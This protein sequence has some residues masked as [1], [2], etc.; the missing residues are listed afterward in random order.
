MRLTELGEMTQ[1]ACFA[2]GVLVV[3][4]VLRI[5]AAYRDKRAAAAAPAGTAPPESFKDLVDIFSSVVTI[6]AIGIGGIWTYSLFI[7]ERA[8]F[9]HANIEQ[10]ISHV[11]FA[12]GVNLMRVAVEITNTGKSKLKLNK[13]DVRVQRVLP[14]KGCSDEVKP[15]VADQI[16]QSLKL[17]EQPVER[18]TWPLHARI[19]RLFDVE[20]EPGEKAVV[21]YE[22][23]LPDELQVVRVYSHL[24][25]DAAPNPTLNTGWQ[26]AEFY[27]F[28]E[29]KKEPAK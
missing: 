12:K 2:I 20:I 5:Y 29:R 13:A 16:N 17:V 3:L 26:L 23:A 27:D 21:D 7:K 1:I 8:D 4:L 24:R 19:D 9:P 18:F 25:N 22:F 6:L 11:A 15:C 14:F 10:K 28:R